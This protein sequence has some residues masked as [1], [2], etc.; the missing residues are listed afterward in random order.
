MVL[1][2]LDSAI[3][4]NEWFSRF[5]G[6]KV[7]HLL[8][9]SSDHKAILIKL[10]GIT[11]RQN[12]PFKFELMWLREGSCS[13]TVI[14]VWGPS[15]QNANMLQIVGKIKAC[16]EKLS[17]WSLQSFGSIKLQV[18]KISKLLSKA[19]IDAVKGRLDYEKVRILRSELNDLLDKESQMWQQRSRSLFLKC[20]DRNTNYFHSKA[21]HRFRRNRISGLR[22]ASNLRCT[23]D[24]VIRNIVCDYY[25]SLFTSSQP[26]DFV[27]IL[28]A[29]KPSVSEV[30]NAQLLRPFLREE[31]EVAIKQM[32]P[33]SALG[34]DSMPPLF[35]QYFW[36]LI[37]V[38]ICSAVLDFLNN[39]KIPLEINSTNITL[40][41]KFKSPELITDF[42]PISLC[43]VVYKIV[44]KVLANRFRDVLPSII[45]EYQSAFQAGRVIIDNILMAFETLHYMKHHQNGKSGLMALKLDMSKAYDWVE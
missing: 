3:A 27:V 21:S 31:V 40:I 10:D 23:E 39:C 37:D 1:E 12:R 22:D 25:Q 28:E 15:S 18:E 16:G 41:P 42:R 24:S 33:I 6:T 20:G 30:M 35:Y 29:V 44:S 9:H 32:K 26:L 43:N 2:R 13:D 17:T 8:T 45:S 5:R 4:S 38:D 36:S 11:L 19:E 7:Q 34:P 14:K